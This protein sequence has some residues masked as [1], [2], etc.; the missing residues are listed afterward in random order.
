MVA[1]TAT[2]NQ[3]TGFDGQ[4]YSD[5]ELNAFGTFECR[6]F[7]ERIIS[8]FPNLSS[9]LR[10]E[11]LHTSQKEGYVQANL[12]LLARDKQLRFKE[13]NLVHDQQELEVFA[14]EQ[15]E[16]CEN[17]RAVLTDT[18]CIYDRCS[19]RAAEFGLT[20][21]NPKDF[22]EKIEPCI[23]RLCCKKW[24]KRQ[25]LRK[26]RVTVESIAREL[27]QVHNHKN[28]YC[29]SISLQS[30]KRQKRANR[31]YLESKIAVNEEGYERTLAE[32]SDLGVSNPSIRRTELI[33]R[34]K[35]FEVVA[36]QLSHQAYFFTVTC[37]S[38][39]HRMTKITMNGKVIKVIPNEKFDGSSPRDAQ[40][41]LSKL[42]AKI[43]SKLKREDIRPYGL[44][45]AE[46]HHDGTPHW[47]F[48]LFVE[49]GQA[50]EMVSIFQRWSLK[51]TPDEKGA[52]KH[53]F[54]VEKIKSGINPKTGNEYSATGYLIKY[55]CKNVDGNGIN[56]CE[57]S[58]SNKDWEEKSSIEVAERIEAW[59]RT[60]RIRQFQQIGG[61]SV[62]VW[63]E[64]RRLSEQKGLIEEVRKAANDG[65]WAEFI[66]LMGGPSVARDSQLARPTYALSES[67]DKATGEVQ[68][69]THTCYGDEAKDRVVGVLIAGIT[70]LSRVHFWEIKD[71]E[72]VLSARQKIMDGIADIFE[73]IRNQSHLYPDDF[74]S[75]VLQRA[76]PAALDSFQ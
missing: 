36:K 30:H 15:A 58:A 12:D 43:N 9:P 68:K 52:Q 29:S 48:L 62:T 23:N 4:I 24:W 44:R 16:Q 50:E 28:L 33:T 53:R 22:S 13:L 3:F 54:K 1:Q 21:P 71:N 37:P 47:H 70:V 27:R 69:V 60:F 25:L 61:P 41:Y 67:L 40:I 2:R 55:I 20:P 42:W 75:V 51:D 7:R 18:Q 59:A 11:Y 76:K 46:P 35:G 39:F 14:G 8:Q 38:R 6:R 56:N 49:P 72:K 31:E 57:E 65:D 73:E 34:L 26:Q 64:M 63:R 66:R 19:E 5:Q 74:N 10:A 45:V 32:L 17:Y